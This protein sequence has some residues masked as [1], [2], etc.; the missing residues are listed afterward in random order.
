LKLLKE[1]AAAQ[2]FKV[3]QEYVDVQTAT[4]TG[5]TA[6]VEMV[7]YLEAHPLVGF[8]LAA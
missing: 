7:E 5:R 1:F 4:A 8:I 2:G 6:V 3:A